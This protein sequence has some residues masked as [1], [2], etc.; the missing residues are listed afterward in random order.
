MPER[1]P[2]HITAEML[3]F[4]LPKSK[5]AELKR[6]ASPPDGSRISTY[7]AFSAYLWRTVSRLRAPLFK[8]DLSAPL[9]WSEAVDMRRRMHS[10]K[11]HP[12]VQQNVMSAALSDRVPVT[13]PAATEVI[14]EWPLGKLAF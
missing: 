9:F 14:S 6:L 10:P 1:H 12:R 4:H 7:D 11:F 2:D 8:P 13:A 3:L 5:A